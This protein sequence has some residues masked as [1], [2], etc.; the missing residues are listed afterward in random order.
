MATTIQTK[1]P[2]KL[3]ASIL[4]ARQSFVAHAATL[5]LSETAFTSTGNLYRRVDISWLDLPSSQEEAKNIRTYVKHTLWGREAEEIGDQLQ[6]YADQEGRIQVILAYQLEDLVPDKPY[7][8]RNGVEQQ[9][10]KFRHVFLLHPQLMG[11]FGKPEKQ[12]DD[13]M[14]LPVE[15][16]DEY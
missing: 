1:L 3:L 2:T 13:P 5:K 9:P 11:M 10:Y 15:E 16:E 12:P 7:T 8:D 6:Q 4:A 14:F